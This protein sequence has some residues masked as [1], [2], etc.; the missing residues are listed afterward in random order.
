MV[1][2]EVKLISQRLMGTEEECQSVVPLLLAGDEKRSLPPLVY[3][4]NHADFRKGNDYFATAFDLI[5]SLYEIDFRDQA[6]DDL[7]ESLKV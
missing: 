3:D 7:R 4:S 1:A 2:A 6:V 5:L